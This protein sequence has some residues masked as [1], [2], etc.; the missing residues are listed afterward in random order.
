MLKSDALRYFLWILVVLTFGGN[1]FALLMRRMGK[2]ENK[3]QN[4]F[5]C[6]L[7]ISDMLMGIYLAGIINKEMTTRGSYYLYDFNWRSGRACHAF[8]VISVISS[9]V[10]VFTLV[11]I[12]YDRFLH[13]VRA[14][15]FKEIVYSTAVILLI[16]TWV[17]CTIIAI[18]PALVQ[19]YFFD[20]S[21]DVAFYGTSSIC[22]P[23]QLPGEGATA[24]EYCL[25]VFGL[26]NFFAA[27]Y[28]IVTYI[29]M[30]YSSYKSAQESG[31][32]KRLDVQP[33]LAKRFAVIIFTDVCC[34][35]PIAMLLFLSLGRAVSDS[36]NV[37]YAVFSICVIPINSA[38][39]PILYTIGTPFFWDKIK[40]Y[41]VRITS[42]CKAGM[43]DGSMYGTIM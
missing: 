23:L 20:K 40:G 2:D 12:A 19:P 43:I 7:S 4:L 22:L 18:L 32:T 14:L 25:A 28:L 17:A 3:V 9:E 21:K 37:L 42:H 10:S 1:L 41:L 5:I 36:D 34:W 13:I 16:I 35:V 24:W 11:F 30:F 26:L 31:N 8:G 29:R 39:N 27:I 6:S 33:A 38:I 15:D